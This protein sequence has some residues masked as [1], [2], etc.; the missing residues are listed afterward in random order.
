M[1]TEVSLD[2]TGR[3]LAGWRSDPG[4]DQVP[5][6]LFIHGFTQT[7]RCG[8]P[9]V[10]A[11]A[12]RTRV[13]AC[14]APGHGGSAR[15]RDAD[16][17]GA[18]RLALSTV[19]EP[20]VLFG[21]SMGGRICLRAALERPGALRGLVLV[22]AT[23]GIADAVRRGERRT[24][25]LA[26]ADHLEAV[27]VDR[28]VEEWLGLDLFATLPEGARFDAERRSNTAAGLAQSLRNCGT[29]SMEPM[30]DRL[31]EIRVPV[32]CLSGGADAAF[33]DTAARMTDGIR[34]G[35][36]TATHVVVDGAGHAVHL[37][38][39][40]EVTAAIDAFLDRL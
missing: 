18:S 28:F 4:G 27:G 21:Y 26:L 10:D 11:L 5:P 15:H 23:P 39:P 12:A 30:W 29:G 1:H 32:L 25:D 20:T 9:V 40:D 14:D 17:V 35:G 31:G 24:R 3:T 36:G 2:A 37:E 8:G 33:T 13:T 38:R 19:Q 34:A 6:V 22:G 16:V 7:A